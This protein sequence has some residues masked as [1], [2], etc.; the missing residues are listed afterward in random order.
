[1]F[2]IRPITNYFYPQG[3]PDFDPYQN[4]EPIEAEGEPDEL[5]QEEGIRE[6][7]DELIQQ[8]LPEIEG[9]VNRIEGDQ[10]KLIRV[11]KSCEATKKV[12]YVALGALTI[13]SSMLPN[14]SE[15]AS[16]SIM[17]D[18]VSILST[19]SISI[20]SG[21]EQAI[22]PRAQSIPAAIKAGII[23]S[24]A[25]TAIK[26]GLETTF[27]PLVLGSKLFTG[28]FIPMGMI[29]SIFSFITH[30]FIRTECDYDDLNDRPF[31]LLN[32]N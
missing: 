30:Y 23:G 31:R 14:F 10:Q 7:P 4:R 15:L 11:K 16:P 12:C 24:I 2:L 3:E 32:G 28:T 29:G 18:W 19:L 8:G 22:Q 27:H 6:F 17:I 1:M 25:G 20:I 9:F 21:A 5:H 13:F 26:V